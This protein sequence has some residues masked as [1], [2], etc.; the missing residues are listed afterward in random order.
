MNGT[1]PQGITDLEKVAIDAELSFDQRGQALAAIL[2]LELYKPTT[3]EDYCTSR[4]QFSSDRARQLIDGAQVVGVLRATDCP[5]LP[6]N[7][8]QVRPLTR[9]PGDRVAEV[10]RYIVDSSPDDKITADYVQAVA[11]HVTAAPSL[12]MRYLSRADVPDAR[13]PSDN[14]YDVPL[15]LLHWQATACD[16]PFG[17]WSAKGRKQPFAGTVHFYTDDARFTALWDDPTPVL[18]ARC[19]NAVE[20]N[21]SVY[22]Q[23]PRIVGLYR[24]YQKRWLARYWQSEGV[25]IFVDLNVAEEFYQDN[26]VGVPTGWGAY[27]TRGYSDRL[28]YTLQEYELAC[29]RR[30]SRDVLFVVYGGGKAVK[31]YSK[32]HGW[33]WFAEHMDHLHKRPIADG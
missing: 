32:A 26:L 20:P 10:W 31:E 22:G 25:H 16:L 15:L 13:W 12:P 24:I 19:V 28:D 17:V 27:A 29:E 3:F 21:F 1:S 7:E 33:L 14:D 18:N 2:T 11:D 23:T 8:A 5:L 6:A 4:L 9:L 30:G